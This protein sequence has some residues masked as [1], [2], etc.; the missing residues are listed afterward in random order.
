MFISGSEHRPPHHSQVPQLMADQVGWIASDGQEY[1]PVVRAALTYEM[2][3]AT[4]PFLDGNGRTA[5]LPLNHQLMRDGYPAA[6]LL[7]SAR[8]RYIQALEQAHHGQHG[9]LVN[10][11]GRAVEGWLDMFL[12]ACAAV[13][14]VLMRPLAEVAGGCAIDAG[15]LGWL[16]RAGRIAGQKRRGR[17]YT[18]ENAV[19]RYQREM[20]EHAIQIGR[21]SK[22]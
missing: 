9:P 2:L 18:S 5:R 20:A 17:W 14:E 6:L 12:E 3:L 22:R 11:I 10:A 15:Y 7:A 8:P 21:P 13:P 16:L 4:H 19:R 1:T